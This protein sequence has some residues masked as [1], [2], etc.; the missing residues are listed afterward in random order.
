MSSTSPLSSQGRLDAS[1][2]SA[3]REVSPDGVDTL[4]SVSRGTGAASPASSTSPEQFRPPMSFLRRLTSAP[5][6]S[7]DDRAKR[8][9]MERKELLEM[10]LES[11]ANVPKAVERIHTN[12]KLRQALHHEMGEENSLLHRFFDSRQQREEVTLG[13][14][15]WELNRP[16]ESEDEDDAD[17]S[18]LPA[19]A[20]GVYDNYEHSQEGDKDD[21]SDESEDSSS[22]Y[23][24]G[25]E[26]DLA[27]AVNQLCMTDETLTA[28]DNMV[29]DPIGIVQTN[30]TGG[31]SA[32]V[33]SSPQSSLGLGASPGN[34]SMDGEPVSALWP[35]QPNQFAFTQEEDNNVRAEDEVYSEMM[36]SVCEDETF[37]DDVDGDEEGEEEHL[38]DESEEKLF[39]MDDD[40]GDGD[41]EEEL[42]NGMAN[43]GAD[44]TVSDPFVVGSPIQGQV[45]T[46]QH[47]L[48]G[49]S[50]Q[51]A[52][53]VHTVDIK[54]GDDVGN[55]ESESSG[56]DDDDELKEYEAFQLRII[57][58]KNRTGFE[59]NQDWRPRAGALIGGRYK[60]E[61]AIGEAVFSRTYKCMDTTTE[62]SVCLK[63]I[64]N[65]KE[66]F[67]QGVDEVR[68]LEYID[69]N[70]KVD[71]RHLIR[72]LDAFY[73]REHLIIVTELLRDNLYEFSR[74]L[75]QRGVINYFSIPRLKK[76]TIEVL[77]A[78][79]TLHSLGLV[80]CDLKPE[81]ILIQ[82]FSACT[83]KVIDF[84]SACFTTDELT[85]YVQS[86]SYRAPEV[87][88]GLMYDTKIDLW[89]LGCVIAEMFTGEVLFRN[90][91]EQTL[92]ARIL[93]TIGP[94]PASLLAGRGEL[95]HQLIDTG[96]F[97]VDHL[98]NG[99]L[100]ASLHVPPL[101]Q[102]VH[103]KD[104][105]FLD[106]LRA[107]LQIDPARRL[108]AREALTHPWLQHGVFA[109][110]RM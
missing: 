94:I 11:I 93:A 54:E 13:D 97:T 40:D 72:L 38:N 69:R 76:I 58:E 20:L 106:F 51:K 41:K 88:L 57:R 49:K 80:H 66:Y 61:M 89:S 7:R 73:F 26:N 21:D 23:G 65:N 59:P 10:I 91:S 100:A 56:D 1:S 46:F 71:E 101:E 25:Y 86:R 70:C 35:R 77:E 33:S 107:L 18:A 16:S 24:S 53:T 42:S 32:R 14:T 85:S 12:E 79:D 22:D 48:D 36:S 60:V 84:G 103:T 34:A 9:E 50:K 8:K 45:T 37:Q 43:F 99:V 63:I 28:M 96:L 83:V 2:T 47:D 98:G 82:N 27:E 74:L 29:S 39:K 105:E 5:T 6:A 15:R 3:S 68:V 64:K 81:N 102:A 104:N 95:Q 44:D 90:D 17:N 110:N 92:L 4:F 62:Q 67:D 108:S 78:L 30:F 75:L 31:S 52:D 109:E 55:E 19:T 87:I